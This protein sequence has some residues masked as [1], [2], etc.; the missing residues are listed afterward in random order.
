MVSCIAEEY[1]IAVDLGATKTRIA[2]CT[3]SE[4]IEKTVYYTPKHGDEYTI[5]ESIYNTV[6]TK[7]KNLVSNIK[8]VG[9]ASIGP[10]DIKEGKVVH[11][12]NVPIRNFE[13]LRPLVK[14]FKK[15]VYVVND[16]V[17]AAWGEK[18]YG[19]AVNYDNFIYLT[20][21]TGVG[22][23]VVVDG[24][25]LIGKMG[26]AHEVG[27]I[28]IDFTSDL[29]C[30]CGGRGHWEVFSGGANTHKVLKY[31]AERIDIT[32]YSELKERVLKGEQIDAKTMF[33]YF[34]KGDPLAKKAVDLYIQATSAGI[35][36]IVNV[37]DPELV[38]IGGSIFLN[39]I[40]VLYEPIVSRIRENIVTNPPIIK[41]TRLGDDVGL[42]G[43][44]AIAVYTPRKIFEIQGRLINEIIGVTL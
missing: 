43:A 25:L 23:G 30:G 29:Q 10:L 33:D 41:P 13:L 17:A 16:C 27:H 18:Y 42:Y 31:L 37:Y 3:R 35:A 39:N 22:A 38:I 44:L 12:S 24:N 11:A 7:W 20:L 9:I 34:R 40:D 4:I 1:Y 5:A 14:K 8:A 6:V 15:P 19:D 21:S 28:V 2:L 36:S 26:N 32:G